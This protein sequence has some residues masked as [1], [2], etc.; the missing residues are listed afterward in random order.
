MYKGFHNNI[1]ECLYYTLMVIAGVLTAGFLMFTN[2]TYS[3]ICFLGMVVCGFFAIVIEVLEYKYSKRM[4]KK[5]HKE[6]FREQNELYSEKEEN[7]EKVIES[8]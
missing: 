1:L 6:F 5:Y 3:N 8:E 4:W 2:N 7:V